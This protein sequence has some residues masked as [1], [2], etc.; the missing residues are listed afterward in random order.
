MEC[1]LLVEK[2][3]A[4]TEQRKEEKAIPGPL[5]S[6]LL[7][8]DL[9]NAV[10]SM[11]SNPLE[12]P[13]PSAVPGPSSIPAQVQYPPQV[14]PMTLQQAQSIVAQAQQAST[15]QNLQ[16]STPEPPPASVAN[17]SIVDL[18]NSKSLLPIA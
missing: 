5:Y 3:V 7:N 15:P 8:V 12:V 9:C 10:Q 2:Y 4:A 11:H 13:S 6:N 14:T 1:Y 17:T 16:T 18:G